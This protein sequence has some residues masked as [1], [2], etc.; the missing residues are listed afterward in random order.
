[1]FLCCSVNQS[2]MYTLVIIETCKS[3][4]T[5]VLFQIHKRMTDIKN[6]FYPYFTVNPR[7]QCLDNSRSLCIV[8]GLISVLFY[9][10]TD[11]IDHYHS[12]EIWSH[13]QIMVSKHDNA[14]RNRLQ[15][16]QIALQCLPSLQQ[17]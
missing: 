7:R 9:F 15:V 5:N 16:L 2:S 3:I 4:V 6:L 11:T 1:M 8:D 12:L 13:F 17:M 10:F 14:I